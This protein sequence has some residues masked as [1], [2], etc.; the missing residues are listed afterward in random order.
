M[1]LYFSIQ[2]YQESGTPWWRC[3]GSW[4]WLL[5][6]KAEDLKIL[7]DP[8]SFNIFYINR[9]ESEDIWRPDIFDTIHLGRSD[10]RP[11]PKL[12]PRLLVACGSTSCCGATMT[13][14]MQSRH[15]VAHV[16]PKQKKKQKKQTNTLQHIA[17]SISSSV[18][19]Q[20]GVPTRS[21]KL[22]AGMQ[23]MHSRRCANSAVYAIVLAMPLS[24]DH[25]SFFIIWIGVSDFSFN[26][27]GL[28]WLCFLRRTSKRIFEIAHT[29]EMVS[30][31]KTKS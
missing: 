24:C 13:H 11:M 3:Q 18:A 10:S 2:I 7:E 8:P 5:W 20:N 29:S 4:Q 27:F 25:R 19:F 23:Y 30:E 6:I 16:T 17:T 1:N 12:C 22:W 15:F 14:N 21:F 28:W 26:N 31:N 9:S